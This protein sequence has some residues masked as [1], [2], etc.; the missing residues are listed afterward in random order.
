MQKPRETMISKPLLIYK[1]LQT[2]QE[3][4]NINVGIK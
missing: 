4:K 2:K 3:S 1:T